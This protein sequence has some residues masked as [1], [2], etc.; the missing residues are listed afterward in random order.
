MLIVACSNFYS[1]FK[2]FA[3]DNI[4]VL[5]CL[6]IV[7]LLLLSLHKNQ[8]KTA[9][10]GNHGVQLRKNKV[11]KSSKVYCLTYMNSF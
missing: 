8:S 6:Y 3:I 1:V 5:I 9:P 11:V 10:Y 2:H 7:Q 4:V